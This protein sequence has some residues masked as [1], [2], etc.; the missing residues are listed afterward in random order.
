[1]CAAASRA[2]GT[3]VIGLRRASFSISAGLCCS[4]PRTRRSRD[5]IADAAMGYGAPVIGLRRVNFF[6]ISVGLCC[7]L[8]RARHSRDRIAAH[9]TPVIGLRRAILASPRLRSRGRRLR[10]SYGFVCQISTCG[11]GPFY[12]QW[13]S[14]QSHV[15]AAL[16]E[17]AKWPDL[18]IRAADCRFHIAPC[19]PFISDQAELFLARAGEANGRFIKAGQPQL[20]LFQSRW[21]SYQGRQQ[22]PF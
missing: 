17:A 18:Q 11:Q 4:L 2:R 6:S 14:Y 21:P 7:S 10:N 9:G 8:S 3:P 13:P 12:Q 16:P 5:R 19:K 20:P 1:M 22:W 15:K